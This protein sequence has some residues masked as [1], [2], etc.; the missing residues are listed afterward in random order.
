MQSRLT[1]KEGHPRGGF[2]ACG[3]RMA[4]RLCKELNLLLVVY[5]D[6]FKMSGPNKI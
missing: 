3:S 1:S 2:R 5:V 4:I 6:D